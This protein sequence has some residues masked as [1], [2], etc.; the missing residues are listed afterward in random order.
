MIFVVH[1]HPYRKI[2]YVSTE[3][4][5]WEAEEQSTTTSAI[6]PVT[7]T[8]SSPLVALLRVLHDLVLDALSVGRVPQGIQEWLDAFHQPCMLH[9]I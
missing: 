6:A 1:W 4:F 5:L 9:W 7:H 8:R 2:Q 3:L